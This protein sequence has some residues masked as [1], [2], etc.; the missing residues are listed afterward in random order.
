MISEIHISCRKETVFILLIPK[1]KKKKIKGAIK[2]NSEDSLRV[3]DHIFGID[4][5][6]KIKSK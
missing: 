4:T 3:I 6:K 2:E 5:D 1:K